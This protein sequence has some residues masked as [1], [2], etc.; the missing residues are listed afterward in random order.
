MITMYPPS[1]E[2]LYSDLSRQTGM[3]KQEVDMF[4]L[5]MIRVFKAELNMTGKTI[6][7][8]LGKF[9]LKR[10]P[11]RKRSVKDFVTDERYIIDVPARN[12]LKFK[13]NKKFKRLFK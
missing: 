9:Y 3:S 7:P 5:S 6:M 4:I 2:K 13:V 8:Y 11:S 12:K 1:Y 10:L